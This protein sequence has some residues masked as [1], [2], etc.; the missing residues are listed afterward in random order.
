MRWL[1]MPVKINVICWSKRGA[2]GDLVARFAL[3][4]LIEMGLRL[5]VSYYTALIH[6][7]ICFFNGINTQSGIGA[8]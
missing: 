1:H 4:L 2:S 5:P 3:F 7:H 8:K 6:K